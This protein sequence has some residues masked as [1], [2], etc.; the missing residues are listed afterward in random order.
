VQRE[1]LLKDIYRELTAARDGGLDWLL[2]C[3]AKSVNPNRSCFDEDDFFRWV[4]KCINAI[5]TKHG[6]E[7]SLFDEQCLRLLYYVSTRVNVLQEE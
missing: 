5:K 1:K 7:V 6:E 2:P 4:E 3:P